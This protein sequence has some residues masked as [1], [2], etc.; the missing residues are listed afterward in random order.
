SSNVE[1][2]ITE[3]EET[4]GAEKSSAGIAVTEGHLSLKPHNTNPILYEW[5]SAVYHARSLNIYQRHGARVKIA[6]AADFNG[7]RWTV[8][9]V[10]TPVPHRNTF[11]MPVGS[12]MRLFMRH[13]GQHGVA[14]TSGSSSLDTA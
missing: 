3:L 2:R 7:T 5:I 6:T 13:N 9:A 11:L 14:V 1:T 4:I 10:Q 8:T 12:I